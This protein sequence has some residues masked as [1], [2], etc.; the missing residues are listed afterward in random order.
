MKRVRLSDLSVM[1]MEDVEN[2][3]SSYLS[4]MTADWS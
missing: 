1:E 2:V 4:S 3:F